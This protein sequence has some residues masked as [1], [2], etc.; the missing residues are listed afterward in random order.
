MRTPSP[1]FPIDICRCWSWSW[2]CWLVSLLGDDVFVVWILSISFVF[3]RPVSNSTSIECSHWTECAL[4]LFPYL[5]LSHLCIPLRQCEY[6][7]A[8]WT[9]PFLSIAIRL[10]GQAEKT[11]RV[12]DCLYTMHY[13]L[14]IYSYI[15]AHDVFT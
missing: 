11:A 4:F 10:G 2:S 13:T 1:V 8:Q 6:T 12:F 9:I 14:Y 5:Y 3:F 15:Q 7:L